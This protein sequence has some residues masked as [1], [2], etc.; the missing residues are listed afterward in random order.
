M[1]YIKLIV[2]RKIMSWLIVIIITNTASN[3][4]HVTASLYRQQLH[5]PPSPPPPIEGEV[6]TE[7]FQ[8]LSPL[9]L[10]HPVM[11]DSFKFLEHIVLYT[12]NGTLDRRP[13][14]ARGVQTEP[15]ALETFGLLCSK[16]FI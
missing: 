2:F 1:Q 6:L 9:G 15:E 13:Y 8:V 7:R 4:W 11:V 10:F 3:L 5:P 12:V 16:C 14:K